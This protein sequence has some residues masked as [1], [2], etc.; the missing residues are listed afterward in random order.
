MEWVVG[1]VTQTPAWVYLLLAYLVWIGIKARR[2]GQVSLT[3]LAIVP[4]LLT[5]W[6][7]HDLVRLY[8]IEAA[9]VLP[10]L[11]ALGLGALLGL[12]LLRGRAITADRTRGLIHRLADGT[13]LPLVLVA[14]AL[15]YTFGV[16]GAVSPAT[17]EQPFWRPVD[18]GAYGLFAGIFVGKFLGYLLRYLRAAGPREGPLRT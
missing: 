4:A 11:G 1:I 13:V 12:W 10:W 15:K 7:L 3:R 14:F 9:T 18:L 8:G 6:G 5:A 17:L 2:P 16:V